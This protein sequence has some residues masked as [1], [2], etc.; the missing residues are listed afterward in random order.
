MTVLGF[1]LYADENLQKIRK[2]DDIGRMGKVKILPQQPHEK[3]RKKNGKTARNGNHGEIF[4]FQRNE[5]GSGK[6]DGGGNDVATRGVKGDE[7]AGQ[8]VYHLHMHIIPRRKND[9]LGEVGEWPSFPGAKFEIEE[10]HKQVTM[11][12]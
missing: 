2:F 8:T 1:T 11:I 10:I 5:N 3:L 4:R 12:K 7:S 6:T 9:G